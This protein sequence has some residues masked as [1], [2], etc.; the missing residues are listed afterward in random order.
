MRPFSSSP[1]RM[2]N[3]P[4]Y[5]LFFALP[6][7]ATWAGLPCA[8]A[9]VFGR[10]TQFLA[11][12]H[13]IP[14]RSCTV[15]HTSPLLSPH[16]YAIVSSLA[17]GPSV[18][19][20]GTRTKRISK[21]TPVSA[22]TT[23][24]SVQ[25]HNPVHC[26]A[27]SRPS[28]I[29]KQ[30]RRVE[31]NRQRTRVQRRFRL[32]S[33]HAPTGDQP[34]AISSLVANLRK[35]RQYQTLHGVTGS[36]KTFMMANII[37]TLN[38][39]TLIL[40]PNKTLAAQLCSEFSRYFP[41]NA[42]EFFVSHFKHYQPEAY[43]PNSDKY[44]A[45]SSSVDKHID[46]LRHAATKSLFERSDTIVVA[47][48]SSIYG[49]GLPSE[50]LLASF[51][52]Q[53]EASFDN[54]IEGFTQALQSLSYL[55]SA[56]EKVCATRGLF[57]ATDDTVF[58]SPPWL[59]EGTLY[60]LAFSDTVV[61]HADCVEFP[62]G[63][64]TSLAPEVVIYP[65]KHFTTPKDRLEIAISQIE[66]ETQQT[67]ANFLKQG[68]ILEA[69]RLQERVTAD[70]EMMRQVG[71]CTG[72]ENYTMFLSCRSPGDPPET[73][74]DYM[75]R[76]GKWLLFIDES[77]VTVPQLS[78]MHA[79]NAARK[80]K[81][82]HHGFRLPSSMENR[83]LSHTEFWAK[84][85]QTIFVSATP[86]PFELEKSGASGV[87]EAVIRPTGVVDPTVKVVRSQGQLEHLTVELARVAASGGKAI[88]TTITKRFAEDVAQ[89]LAAKPPV[90]G[91]LDRSLRVSFLHSG[92][93]SVGRMQVLEAMRKDLHNCSSEPAYFESL[94]A[95]DPFDGS[96]EPLEHSSLDVIVGVNLLREGIDLPAV[97][98]V[99]IL[100]ADSE[101]FLR[102]ETALI[103]TIGR[104]AR[105]TKG[106]VIM[107]ADTVTG[108]MQ[109]AITET[110]R[111]RKLQTAYNKLYNIRPGEVGY[112]EEGE[113]NREHWSVLNRIRKLSLMEGTNLPQRLSKTQ[114]L[115]SSRVA[116]NQ[117]IE[118]TSF[119]DAESLDELRSR[120]LDAA[121][122][123]DFEMA[124][125]LRDRLMKLS[126]GKV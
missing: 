78:A 71:F 112:S 43:I 57:H 115:L 51:P 23:P 86:G 83:P 40:A 62:S 116:K 90:S 98:L 12:R 32:E 16:R 89:C 63:L 59:P 5:P 76:D 126:G 92:I 49:L 77:H 110:D 8:P 30:D 119:P 97:Q 94:V 52:V 125:L 120:M 46:R 10:A 87:V 11:Y 121:E 27:P 31:E 75:P 88:V 69:S 2:R 109:R 6:S 93:D 55:P 64:T 48:V 21:R 114:V 103:Q 39:P 72:M 123:Q 99:A 42:V 4:S 47:S 118:E 122:N 50:Y 17:S 24:S 101:G 29:T 84:A 36:G 19:G 96:D 81:L 124:A 25:T 56:F 105:N 18:S 65:A 70:I 7:A 106:H 1:A 37:A 26:D 54:G 107:Y 113:R 35:G 28:T 61:V 44:I 45:K 95:A 100:D 60:R 33:D 67:V 13:A 20:R 38:L 82:I 117:K 22:I 79:G 80:R 74:L 14:L 104:A 85:A 111:R 15:T 58:L 34:K 68:Q 66:L 91:I 108:A 9:S 41:T 53:V 102:G 3:L 73:F